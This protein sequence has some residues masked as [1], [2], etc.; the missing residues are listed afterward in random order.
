M[1]GFMSA[2]GLVLVVGLVLLIL[3]F[4]P[5]VAG[6]LGRDASRESLRTELEALE[7]KKEML[8]QMQTPPS[9]PQARQ[10]PA[11]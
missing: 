11:A 3:A 8:R 1:G 10:P 2:L 7:R 6:W 4:S 9:T 5:R